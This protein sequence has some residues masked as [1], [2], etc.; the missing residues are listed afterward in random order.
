MRL[1]HYHPHIVAALLASPDCRIEGL[2]ALAY[3]IEGPQASPNADIEVAR[4]VALAAELLA[5]QGLVRIQR[6]PARATFELTALG[7]SILALDSARSARPPVT[8]AVALSV[9]L[10]GCASMLG[11]TAPPVANLPSLHELRRQPAPRIEQVLDAQQ[12]NRYFAQCFNCSSPT[13]KTLS[14]APVAASSAAIDIT[15]FMPVD[16]LARAQPAAVASPVIPTADVP[17]AATGALQPELP[18][19]PSTTFVER[20]YVVYF[21]FGDSGVDPAAQLAL[22]RI[23]SQLAGAK[24][25]VVV[26]STDS[27]GATEFNKKLADQRARSV[28]TVLT[29]SIAPQQRIDTK[30]T[31]YRLSETVSQATVLGGVAPSSPAATARHAEIVA[32]V[33]SNV[34]PVAGATVGK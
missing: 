15:R 33:P 11:N 9:A 34:G 26:G 27:V 6:T 3:A 20:R 2:R 17:R 30:A 21:R 4:D 14:S 7:R 22:Q 10:A 19:A 32:L 23:A 25:I 16:V 28:A 1:H 8:S 24:S 18:R 13:P 29:R 5:L 31:P 12:G